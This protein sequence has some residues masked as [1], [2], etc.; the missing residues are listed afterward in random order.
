MR[1]H[2]IFNLERIRLLV[3]H[4][5]ENTS[6]LYYAQLIKFPAKT[7]WWNIFFFFF[8]STNN[9]MS[10]IESMAILGVRSF[11]PSEPSYIKF[12]S[13]LTLIVGSNGSGKTVIKE[14]ALKRMSVD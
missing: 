5:V 2:A 6:G 7:P 3:I 10:Q 9:K 11:S 1:F 13:P 4:Q 14:C 8:F 12:F